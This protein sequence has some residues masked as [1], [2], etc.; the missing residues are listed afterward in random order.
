VGLPMADPVVHDELSE[1]ARSWA[2]VT[3]EQIVDGPAFLNGELKKKSMECP[4]G[5]EHEKPK[6]GSCY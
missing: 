2:Q 3:E 6:N 1:Y 4:D 5:L